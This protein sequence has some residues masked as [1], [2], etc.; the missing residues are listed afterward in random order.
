MVREESQRGDRPAGA[1][2]GLLLA[3]VLVSLVG[4]SASA[5]LSVL[6][7]K[8]R[9][10][11][12][13]ISFCAVSESINCDTVS[14]SRFSVLFGVPIST[15]AVLF[16][17]SILVLGA[18]GFLRN[19][20]PWPWALASLLSAG[21][22]SLCALLFLLSEFVI[23]SFCI[24]CIVLYVV[25][26]TSCVLCVMGQRRVGVFIPRA[27]ALFL[28]AIFTGAVAFAIWFPEPALGSRVFLLCAGLAAL[29]SG[30][31]VF[32]GRRRGAGGVLVNLRRDLAVVFERPL[33][34]SGL[35][36]LSVGV[37]VAVLLVT[38]WI[39]PE[40]EREIAGGLGNIAHGRTTGGHNWI[41]AEHP[42][43]VV[44]EYSDYECPHCRRAHEVVREVVRERKEWLRLVHVHMPLDHTCN[45]ALGGRP[46][47]RYSCDCARAAVCA[48]RQNSFWEMNDALFIRRGG[49]DAGGL[50]ILA[51]KMGLDA[52][53]F[54]SCMKSPE[55]GSRLKADLALCRRL[56][57]RPATPTFSVDGKVVVG[58]K[59]KQWWANFVERIRDAKRK[60]GSPGER[61]P[62]LG[63]RRSSE[64]AP[65]E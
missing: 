35:A 31:L 45:P 36:A 6:H 64:A 62:V 49:L 8:V 22:A 21:A 48:D 32:L 18:W 56:G 5:Y 65:A 43:V 7:W 34:G 60:D 63:R 12:G 11:P 28:A 3:L 4:V 14:L 20:A 58:S 33:V 41:G 53:S 25:N 54:R 40:Q 13:H 47:H 30:V 2:R 9:N 50:T 46:F 59:K 61:D 39:Y 37:V 27:V 16:F 44:V 23:R 52:R 55:T 29:G 57:L 24:M 42:E 38:P 15:W 1:G 17:L 10:Q 26:L 19:R 51:A